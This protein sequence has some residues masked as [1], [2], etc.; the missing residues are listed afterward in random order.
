MAVIR[1]G[2]HHAQLRKSVRIPA[3]RDTGRA[4][5]CATALLVSGLAGAADWEIDP[6]RVELTEQ[7]KTGAITLRNTSDRPTSIQIQAMAWSQVDGKDVYTASRE[8]MVSPPIVTIP[9]KG[10]QTIRTALRRAADATQELS[11]RIN[12]QEL[13]TPSVPG[14]LGVQVA[15][16][17]GLPVFVQP[18]SGESTPNLVWS[19]GSLPGYQLK[20]GMKNQGN[21]HIQITD[22]SLFSPDDEKALAS[23]SGSRYVMPGQTQEWVLKRAS[24][25]KLVDPRLHLKAYTDAGDIEAD[26]V[27]GSP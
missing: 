11:Y 14:F 25:K 17:V 1:M 21:T 5:L 4:V 24:T 23:V 10:E 16:R 20:V 13:P 18:L 22:F 9:A 19:V 8:L 12:L 7:Q 15:M 26:L 3:W 27:L 2:H 6:V